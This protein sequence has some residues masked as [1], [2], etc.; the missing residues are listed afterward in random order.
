MEG[1]LSVRLDRNI[2]GPVFVEPGPLLDISDGREVCRLEA[3]RLETPRIAGG[4]EGTL[5]VAVVDDA[6][7]PVTGE[8]A[9]PRIDA[10]EQAVRLVMGTHSIDELAADGGAV[11]SGKGAPAVAR[12]LFPRIEPS[13]P[14]WDRM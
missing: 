7:G 2:G 12:I 4:D 5:S 14:A 11:L 6:D 1:E 3:R 8:G 9:V 10:G 13:L